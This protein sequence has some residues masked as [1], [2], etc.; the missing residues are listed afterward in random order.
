MKGVDILGRGS[1][2]HM[3]GFMAQAGYFVVC[4]EA[5]DALGDSLYE[6]R[7]FVRGSV[8]SLGADCEEKLIS[9]PDRAILASLLQRA[10]IEGAHPSDF[11]LFGSARQLYHFHV[12]NAHAY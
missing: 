6:A 8:K 4:G 3:S 11:R 7:I 9:E 2:G 5:G 1:G 10:G 12:D